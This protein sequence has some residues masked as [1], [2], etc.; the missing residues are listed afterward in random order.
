MEQCGR[1]LE[2][3]PAN[4]VQT[5]LARDAREPGRTVRVNVVQGDLPHVDRVHH[6]AEG[7]DM[8]W[9]S[10]YLRPKTRVVLDTETAFTDA[11]RQ[12]I[13]TALSCRVRS[14]LFAQHSN[15]RM[16]TAALM[17]RQ[18]VS[19]AVVVLGVTAKGYV[20]VA[21]RPLS[22]C[23]VGYSSEGSVNVPTC[24][25]NAWT[26]AAMKTVWSGDA[27]S[28][29]FVG[30]DTSMGTLGGPAHIQASNDHGDADKEV[31]LTAAHVVRPQEDETADP[32]VVAPPLRAI[33]V[34]W[35]HDHDLHY[36]SSDVD[37]HAEDFRVADPD[38][39][40][41]R[42]EVW[43]SFM[44]KEIR[45]FSKRAKNRARH[46]GSNALEESK[47][48][49]VALEAAKSMGTGARMI[50]T[51]LHS[52]MKNRRC[53][54]VP[55]SSFAPRYWRTLS[56]EEKGQ[57]AW[58]LVWV[59]VASIELKTPQSPLCPRTASRFNDYCDNGPIIVA[60]GV[61]SREALRLP[62][63]FDVMK[64]GA[65][66]QETWGTLA[67]YPHVTL[68]VRFGNTS[69][70]CHNML[71]MHGT[72]GQGFATSGDS[73]AFVHARP[74][75]SQAEAKCMGIISA[76]G[77]FD[78]APSRDYVYVSPAWAWSQPSPAGHV[79]Y[80][81]AAMRSAH[82]YDDSDDDAWDAGIAT[83]EATGVATQVAAGA[84]AGVGA[85]DR[86]GAAEESESG[87]Q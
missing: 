12:V 83:G 71:A 37:D 1:H 72:K 67:N 58:D 34:K 13:D 52:E 5:Y 57:E 26:W 76:C 18:G 43:S 55:A 69:V 44:G 54:R 32:W 4:I 7:H 73:G 45:T 14:S 10:T 84:G 9:W 42:A 51:I 31:V 19:Y 59:D 36:M 15:L 38:T 20:P 8:V 41:S 6:D 48:E 29:G 79:G 80:L 66:T 85:S 25:V 39:C 53:A 87:Q 75:G 74:H 86:L 40:R 35:L 2:T 49:L 16:I 61:V 60:E 47:N 64:N 33:E 21:E 23:L 62:T 82:A 28:G 65:M 30:M 3:L 11:Q 81:P 63:T 50:G 56:S 78:G 46:R 77:A 70:V 22:F 68:R 17:H 24:V 27:I